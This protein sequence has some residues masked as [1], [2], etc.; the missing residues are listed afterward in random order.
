MTEGTDAT[1]ESLMGM[2]LA[3]GALT[4]ALIQALVRKQVFTAADAREVF[5]QALLMVEEG[6]GAAP[7]LARAVDV[8][9]RLIEDRLR[10]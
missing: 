2:Q 7:N 10:R 9:R 5:E 3:N 8:A 4:S 1:V 6:R